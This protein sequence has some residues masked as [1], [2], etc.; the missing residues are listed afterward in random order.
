MI[1]MKIGLKLE[2]PDSLKCDIPVLILCPVLPDGVR[3][4]FNDEEVPITGPPISHGRGPRGYHRNLL[5]QDV[6]AARLCRQPL[7]PPGGEASSTP[8]PGPQPHRC[9]DRGSD[10]GVHGQEKDQVRRPP[11]P[12]HRVFCIKNVQDCRKNVSK[13]NN[14]LDLS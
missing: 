5:C 7:G 10:R 11:T 9:S 6:A 12:F 2:Y 8:H 4:G 13:T 14:A 1:E 3:A